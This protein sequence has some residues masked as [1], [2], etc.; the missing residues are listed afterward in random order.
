MSIYEFNLVSA[1]ARLVHICLSVSESGWSGLLHPLPQDGHLFLDFN[2]QDQVIQPIIV[3]PNTDPAVLDLLSGHSLP[4]RRPSRF[5]GE[6]DQRCH[7]RLLDVGEAEA[8]R[9]LGNGLAELVGELDVLVVRQLALPEPAV[10]DALVQVGVR[11]VVLAV[12]ARGAFLA[13]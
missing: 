11:E 6:H 2:P 9:D 5:S 3:R 12:E 10:G 1:A 8:V 13:R 7:K 4:F